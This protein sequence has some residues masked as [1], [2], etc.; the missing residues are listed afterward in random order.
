MGFVKLFALVCLAGFLVLP[1]AAQNADESGKGSE[2]KSMDF[3]KGPGIEVGK[4][5]PEIKLMNQDGEEISVH[6]MLKSGS[7]ALVFFRSAGW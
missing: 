3:A 6:E 4:E 1:A 7:A 5:L 2:M